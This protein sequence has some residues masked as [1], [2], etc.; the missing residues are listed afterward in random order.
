MRCLSR[1]VDPGHK[2]QEQGRF[3][4]FLLHSGKTLI[5][6]KLATKHL[7]ASCICYSLIDVAIASSA[8]YKSLPCRLHL[9]AQVPSCNGI[10]RKNTLTEATLFGIHA[11][12][13]LERISAME[14]YRS[15][16]VVRTNEE[17]LIHCSLSMQAPKEWFHAQQ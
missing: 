14:D 5:D 11:S 2:L 16:A 10:A 4:S 7:G 13:Q 12:V 3:S 15:L 9:Y 6:L 8:N 1:N 17:G